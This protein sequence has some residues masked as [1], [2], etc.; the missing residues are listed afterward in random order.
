MLLLVP[1][2]KTSISFILFFS[3]KKILQIKG[4]NIAFRFI[5][6]IPTYYWMTFYINRRIYN[7][8]EH[9]HELI[10]SIKFFP[11]VK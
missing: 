3:P 2:Y 7:F 8:N 4:V 1:L 6:F 10:S 11:S 5:V 9:K